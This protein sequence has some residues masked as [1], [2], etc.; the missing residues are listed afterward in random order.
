MDCLFSLLDKLGEKKISF[1][2]GFYALGLM[3][4]KGI[5][6][7]DEVVEFI[8]ETEKN[9]KDEYKTEQKTDEQLEEIK[10]LFDK[11]VSKIECVFVD[12]VKDYAIGVVFKDNTYTTIRAYEDIEKIKSQIEK[13]GGK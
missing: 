6:T 9:I 11:E 8:K 10:K 4:E 7:E 13:I 3:V 12:S 1:S 2:I 5:V